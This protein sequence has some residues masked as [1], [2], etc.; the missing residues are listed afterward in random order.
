V[1]IWV[2]W[3]AGKRSQF[4]I[5]PTGR[6][7]GEKT[8]IWLQDSSQDLLAPLL[9]TNPQQREVHQSRQQDLAARVAGYQVEP[10]IGL[11]STLLHLNLIS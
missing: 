4:V 8:Q 7:D 5:I 1:N 6:N 2:T 3:V 9:A 10:A 11:L